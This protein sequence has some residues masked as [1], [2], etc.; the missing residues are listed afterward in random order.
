MVVVTLSSDD[1]MVIRM[2]RLRMGYTGEYSFII[3]NFSYSEI[4]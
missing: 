4:I 3:M 1:G 2:E